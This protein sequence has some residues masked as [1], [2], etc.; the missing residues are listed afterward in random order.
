MSTSQRIYPLHANEALFFWQMRQ[1]SVVDAIREVCREYVY[2]YNMIPDLVFVNQCLADRL[3]SELNKKELP[4]LCVK[5]SDIIYF[6][7]GPKHQDRLADAQFIV[8]SS[9]SDWS[10]VCSM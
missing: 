3:E 4:P 8:V 5:F 10:K 6:Y 1:E 2:K 7:C 9:T